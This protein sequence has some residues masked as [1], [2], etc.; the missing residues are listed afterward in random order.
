[1]V[2]SL[3]V[4]PV[5]LMSAPAGAVDISISGFVRQEVAVKVD[6]REN[7]F[8]T[9][10]NPYNG[11]AVA[12]DPLIPIGNSVTR[13]TRSA[14]N[15]FN[16]FAS[17]LEVNLD[18]V[19]DPSLKFHATLRGYY[20]WNVYD[21]NGDTSFF[22]T[23][24]RGG[25]RGT[26]LEVS[27][28]D[29]MVDLPAAYV[30]YST[31]PLFFRLGN[32]QIAWGEALF[33]R[34]LDVPSGLDLR[35]HLIFD[36]AA[37]EFSDKRVSSPALRT[38]WQIDPVWEVDAFVQQFSPSVVPN[39]STPYNAIP[40]QFTV[41][42]R[43]SQVD[44]S[45]NVGGRLR[46]QFDDL[47]L[48]FMATSRRNPDGAYRWTASGVNKDI[49]GL[50]GTGAILAQTPFEVDGANGVYSATEWFDYAGMVRLSGVGAFNAALGDFAAA[51]AL[52]GSLGIT[53]T[54]DF[55]QVGR[56]LDTL[57]MLMGGTRG[58]IERLYP[59]E[60]VFGF[61]ANYIFSG[62]P[63]TLLD[64][65]IG[66]FELTYT[67]DKTFT[68]P[69]LSQD[70]L[71]KDELA[72]ALVFEKYHRFSEDF[73]ATYIVFQYL[74]KSASDLL[75]RPLD[76]YGGTASQAS[77]GIDGGF[78]ALAVAIQQPSE[79]LEWRFDLTALYDLQ[80]GAMFQPG[81][82]WKPDTDWQV[83]LYATLFAA[84]DNNKNAISTVD[85][86]DEV[87]MRVTRQF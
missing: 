4:A 50:A 15:D 2:A 73:P 62:E 65:L 67:P 69:D 59:Y 16:L 81:V 31:G 54:D 34:V 6:D 14:E 51:G 85:Y 77:T 63:D 1:M 48:Q 68:S 83:D 8:N 25:E 29:Y 75:G 60:N 87:F 45:W 74:H 7:P 55:A 11:V 23:P 36:P 10:G 27:G 19:F 37:E 40:D 56:S 39:P 42:D 52:A 86:A 57:F 5:L 43:Y 53:Q 3:G 17:R 28:K 79:T 18:A 13:P 21:D 66:R 38:S 72:F 76:G 46:A 61:G 9:A 26:L 32:Q 22:E 71:K 82:K 78:N 64:Q 70:F 44:G 84:E 12:T 24:V 30:D 35:R 47:G 41:H 80:G 33:F 20:D 49:A 58:H